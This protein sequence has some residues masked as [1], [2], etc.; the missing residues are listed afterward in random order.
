MIS[1]KYPTHGSA[2]QAHKN[3]VGRSTATLGR[4][5]LKEYLETDPS[6]YLC[7]RVSDA[8]SV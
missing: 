8:R 7:V 2:K 1:I 5:P 4:L 6:E 3:A